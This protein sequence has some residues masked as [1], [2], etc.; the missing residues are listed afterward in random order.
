MPGLD[1][2]SQLI[3]CQLPVRLDT[4]RGCS[5]GC[6]Y[7]FATR[8]SRNRHTD[9]EN[10]EP[11]NP[12][13]AIEKFISGS[14]TKGTEFIDWN[15]P[16]HWGGM[17]D[18]FQPA[19]RK[20]E[21]SLPVLKKLSESGYPF[22]V[23][24][25]STLPME[26]PYFSLFKESNCVLQISMVSEKYDNIEQG[27]P[28]YKE[29]LKMVDKMATHVKRVV[30]RVQP[31]IPEVH[32]DVARA[33]KRYKETGAYGVIFEGM[34]FTHKPKY[35]GL[36]KV[37]NDI[38]FSEDV[39]KPRF[40][41]MKNLCHENGLVFLCGENRLRSMSDERCCCGIGGLEGFKGNEA[42][43]MDIIDGVAVSFTESQKKPGS[44]ACYTVCGQSA[45]Y[46]AHLKGKSYEEET[47]RIVRREG[48]IK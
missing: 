33:L 38:C 30:I 13:Q 22:V 35:K 14:R 29:R 8:C 36:V 2:T 3:H 28:T 40:E 6:K 18:P 37:G 39:L 21:A 32:G 9:F 4:Y 15:I 20:H 31:Y 16:L 5:H 46:S 11:L 34:K 23:S 42:N 19:E 41:E 47:M 10:I 45:S 25:K 44:A 43:V 17:S 24:T 12:L 1:I 26:E 7:C 48:K 27:A